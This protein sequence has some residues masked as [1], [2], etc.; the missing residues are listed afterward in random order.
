MNAGVDFRSD[1]A[2]AHLASLQRYLYDYIC[3][4]SVRRATTTIHSAYLAHHTSGCHVFG[5]G[6]RP[7]LDSDRVH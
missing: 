5:L 7:M 2:Y 1:V 6:D 4:F 3:V